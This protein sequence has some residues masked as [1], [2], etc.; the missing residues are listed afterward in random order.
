MILAGMTVAS[1]LKEIYTSAVAGYV[2]SLCIGCYRHSPH[3]LSKHLL[4]IK[5]Y[6][7]KHCIVDIYIFISIDNLIYHEK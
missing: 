3:E 2:N 4:K 7:Q 6:H 1:I 5:N